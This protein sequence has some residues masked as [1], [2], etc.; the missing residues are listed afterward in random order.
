[1]NEWTRNF[2]GIEHTTKERTRVL[3]G[4]LWHNM[5]PHNY[6]GEPTR[7]LLFTTRKAAREWCIQERAKFVNHS[8]TYAYWRFRPV[9]VRETV[10]VVR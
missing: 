7:A 8:D 4:R 5:T 3:L 6:D 10:R 1:M 9:R 2:W